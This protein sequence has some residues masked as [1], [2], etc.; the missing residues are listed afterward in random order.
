MNQKVSKCMLVEDCRWKTVASNRS[1]WLRKA[2]VDRRTMNFNTK[3]SE[4]RNE[5]LLDT[6]TI[7]EIFYSVIQKMSK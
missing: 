2:V 3:N 4:I 6:K 5:Q 1:E 7:A